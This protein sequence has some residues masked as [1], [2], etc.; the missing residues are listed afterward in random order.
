MS[1]KAKTENQA[2]TEEDRRRFLE[3]AGKLGAAGATMTLALAH[4][5]RAVASGGSYHGGSYEGDQGE[6]NN[7]Q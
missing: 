2:P 1:D 3:L 6:N 5:K 7:E 4:P